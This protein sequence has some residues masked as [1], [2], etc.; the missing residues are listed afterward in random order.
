MKANI[1]KT[2]ANLN[3]RRHILTQGIEG[4][5]KSP[6]LWCDFKNISMLNL[7]TKDCNFF[8]IS[9][10]ASAKEKYESLIY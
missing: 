9:E 10:K 4:L 7:E 1:C 2:C 5:K 3:S 8:T 6:Y